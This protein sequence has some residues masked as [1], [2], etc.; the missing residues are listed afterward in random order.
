MNAK[1]L[2]P[3]VALLLLASATSSAWA[4]AK[5]QA[6]EPAAG[7]TVAAAPAQLRLR[8]NEALEAPFSKIRLVD[9]KDKVI[10][11]SAVAVDKRNPK[12][13]VA[14]VPALARGTYRVQWSTV[15]R[16]GHKVNGEY[17]FSVK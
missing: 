10:A 3:A 11:P 15:T 7:S 5:L 9:A 4:H 14:T 6:A 17:A 12:M 1:H 13:L 2:V 8:F 16:D